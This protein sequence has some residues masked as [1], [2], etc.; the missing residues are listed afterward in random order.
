MNV[1]GWITIGTKVDTKGFNKDMRTLDQ[2]IRQA[3][4][5][6]SDLLKQRQEIQETLDNAPMAKEYLQEEYDN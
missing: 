3:E 6:H 2:Q 5:Q 1:D 4:K